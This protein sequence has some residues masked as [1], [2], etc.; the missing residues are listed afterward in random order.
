MPEETAQVEQTI[1]PE[2]QPTQ[3]NFTF[4][5]TVAQSEGKNLL[6]FLCTKC[7]QIKKDIA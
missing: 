7:G 4:S 6:V 3:H 5:C 2:C 1:S